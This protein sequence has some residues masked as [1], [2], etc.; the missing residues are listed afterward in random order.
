[1]DIQEKMREREK[2]YRRNMRNMRENDEKM[3]KKNLK[4]C[5]MFGTPQRQVCWKA[6]PQLTAENIKRKKYLTF[7]SL[8]GRLCLGHQHWI[9][10]IYNH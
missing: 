5:V 1:V 2:K 6:R 3:R 7:P 4:I 9:S 8:R 10:T